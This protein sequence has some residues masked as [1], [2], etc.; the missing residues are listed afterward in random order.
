MSVCMCVGHVC[1]CGACVSV[2]VC[3]G[4][5]CVRG[6][7]VCVCLCRECVCDLVCVFVEDV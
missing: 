2:C 5:V 1:V 6:T 4:H 7:C 3:V